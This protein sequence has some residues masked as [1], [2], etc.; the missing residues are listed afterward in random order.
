MLK[1]GWLAVFVVAGCKD[2]CDLTVS[3]MSAEVSGHVTIT[4]NFSEA[5]PLL[6]LESMDGMNHIVVCVASSSSTADCDPLEVRVAT[7][8]A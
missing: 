2:Q 6:N 1:L 7:S 8:T 3:T 4:G 5:Q